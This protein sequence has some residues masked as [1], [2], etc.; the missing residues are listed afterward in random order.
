VILTD[1]Q[2]A[3]PLIEQNVQMNQGAIDKGCG[4]IVQISELDVMETQI[5]DEL[6]LPPESA[7]VQS[8]LLNDQSQFSCVEG[9]IA[10][11]K[12]FQPHLILCADVTYNAG[13]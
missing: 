11:A 3:L 6:E 12:E 1:L 5:T 2:S 4:K 13:L 9:I 7:S 10:T 8:T